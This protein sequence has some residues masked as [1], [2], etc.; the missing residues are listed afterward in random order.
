MKQEQK[1]IV[2]EK[3]KQKCWGEKEDLKGE[4]REELRE[5]G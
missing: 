2:G 4:K 1:Q 5:V 3:E